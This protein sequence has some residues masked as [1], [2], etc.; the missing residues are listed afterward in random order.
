MLAMEARETALREQIRVSEEELAFKTTSM[1][2]TARSLSD[3]ESEL[4]KLSAELGE[5]SFLTDSQR[6]EIVANMDQVRKRLEAGDA[7]EGA[8][9]LPRGS[10]L[11][12]S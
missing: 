5:R 4:S 9:L 10:H 1:H 6:V 12:I 2:E 8:T 7:I 11:R 3:K